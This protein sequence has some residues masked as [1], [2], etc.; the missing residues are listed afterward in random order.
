MSSIVNRDL[1]EKGGIYTRQDDIIVKL[2]LLRLKNNGKFIDL[3]RKFLC[4]VNFL[5]FAYCKVKDDFKILEEVKV[6]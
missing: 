5:K 6:N 1:N 4:D 3:T 2:S